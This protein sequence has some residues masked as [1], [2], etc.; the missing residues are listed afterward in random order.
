MITQFNIL[1]MVMVFVASNNI[2]VVEEVPTTEQLVSILSDRH[3]PAVARIEAERLLIGRVEENHL[4][5]E[6]RT[7]RGRLDP[8]ALRFIFRELNQFVHIIE[9]KEVILFEKVVDGRI[10]Y[11]APGQPFYPS[12]GDDPE[13][14]ANRLPPHAQ[15]YYALG[16]VWSDLVRYAEPKDERHSIFNDLLDEAATEFQHLKLVHGSRWNWTPPVREHVLKLYM[17]Q[18]HS[19][20]L[21]YSAAHTLLD[22]HH[23]TPHM[24]ILTIR[25]E[26][27]AAAWAERGSELA[28]RMGQRLRETDPRVAVLKMDWYDHEVEQSAKTGRPPGA[29]HMIDG[30]F[31]NIS[32]MYRDP[33]APLTEEEL[34]QRDKRLALMQEARETGDD[35]KLREFKEEIAEQQRKEFEQRVEKVNDWIE[36]NRE[37]LEQEAEAF[38]EQQQGN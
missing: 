9:E 32:G 5:E 11:R 1:I 24:E 35:T 29:A 30:Y 28:L 18:D 21:R 7:M 26:L 14:D 13:G 20:R 6:R 17:N 19:A 2:G 22:M 33:R 36:A 8:Q 25:D 34:E 23:A 27:V 31:G 4:I 15:V 16:R 3:V 12:S 38:A 10:E 37:R